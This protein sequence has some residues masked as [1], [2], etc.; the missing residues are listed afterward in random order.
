MRTW[1]VGALAGIVVI[2]IVGIAIL[3]ASTPKGSL[4]RSTQPILP[5]S[6]VPPVTAWPMPPAALS[7]ALDAYLSNPQNNADYP[8][9]ELAFAAY[10]DPRD[11]S[12]AVFSI[13]GAPGFES[14]VQGEG[15]IAR[16]V[17]GVWTI[18]DAG[19]VLNCS[20]VPQNV[21]RDLDVTPAE[22]VEATTATTGA[23]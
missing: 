4:K 20:L 12:W 22:C 3:I 1:I 7:Q 19:S 18:V 2:A 8:L 15:G 11:P 23:S 5:T 14:D 10:R 13:S 21:L 9:N 6:T 17:R 16:L